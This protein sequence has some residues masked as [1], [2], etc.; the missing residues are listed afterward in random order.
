MPIEP[1]RLSDADRDAAVAMLRQHVEAGR[2]DQQ[3]FS[4]RMGAAL[5]ARFASDLEPLFTDLPAPRPGAAAMA[6]D[7]G[8]VASA[9]TPPAG[10]TPPPTQAL[11]PADQRAKAFTMISRFTWPVAILLFLVTGEFFWIIAAIV[12]SIVMSKLASNDR[13]PPPPLGS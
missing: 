11:S 5:A 9:W 4:D 8:L 13:T 2:L 10:W 1:L 6:S 3:E 7:A 12:V